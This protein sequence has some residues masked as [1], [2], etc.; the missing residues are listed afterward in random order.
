MKDSR[1]GYSTLTSEESRR[2]QITAYTYGQFQTLFG[3][4]IEANVQPWEYGSESVPDGQINPRA[5]LDSLSTPQLRH[6]T[7]FK[8]FV[9]SWTDS[10][11]PE[12]LTYNLPG[13]SDLN[14]GEH[15]NGSRGRML[16]ILT[17]FQNNIVISFSLLGCT[18]LNVPLNTGANTLAGL[19]NVYRLTM[20]AR[21]SGLRTIWPRR[22]LP[23]Q[24]L[25]T[26]QTME[27]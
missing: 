23:E 14:K 17:P 4:D 12:A 27:R 1:F 21:N 15:T 26:G 7:T 8:D 10:I 13:M 5:F 20:Q 19:N 3:I 16:P 25:S 2:F 24:T 22:S 9:L 18:C 6:L 11:Y